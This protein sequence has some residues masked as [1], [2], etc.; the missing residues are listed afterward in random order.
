MVQVAIIGAGPAGVSCAIALNQQK[1]RCTLF[2]RNPHA[3][4]IPESCVIFQDDVFDEL[5][6][7]DIVHHCVIEASALQFVSKNGHSHLNLS[8]LFAS[9]AACGSGTEG[10]V[11]VDRTKLN[12]LLREYARQCQIPIV[13]KSV[14]I[15][16]REQDN[17]ITLC[18]DSTESEPLSIGTY[19]YVVDATGKLD[20]IQYPLQQKQIGE[21]LDKRVGYFSQFHG[22][23]GLVFGTTYIVTLDKSFI[24]LIPI[25]ADTITIGVTVYDK[26]CQ[27]S[28]ETYTRVLNGSPWVATL[29][30]R[31]TPC[32]PVIPVLNQ[33]SR[34]CASTDGLV[35]FVGDS[36]GFGDPFYSSGIRKSIHSGWIAAKSIVHSI[37]SQTLCTSES[38]WSE[39]L[40]A[41]SFIE[42]KTE[43]VRRASI[44]NLG[45]LSL[46]DPHIHQGIL[47]C[48]G[49]LILGYRSPD[50]SPDH[51]ANSSPKV[52]KT[53]R[54]EAERLYAVD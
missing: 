30:G 7:S 40:T 42:T 47:S 20:T 48:L 29:V 25:N 12:F 49:N 28:N 8:G 36:M 3:S 50:R 14:R 26:P 33:V 22:M 52:L 35:F 18:V 19:D 27:E 2:E 43:A 6:L 53:I 9:E 31:L 46:A 15:V 10:I 34:V 44:P 54:R 32:M 11:T 13:P 21:I 41:Y 38:Y 5:C 23:H 4:L 16:K 45:L 51:N 37:A 17:R 24:Y 39:H 1:V